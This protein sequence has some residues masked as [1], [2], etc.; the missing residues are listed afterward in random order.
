ML[1]LIAIQRQISPGT[2]QFFFMFSF[3]H[4]YL[5]IRKDL[6]LQEQKS[7][8]YVSNLKIFNLLSV[9]FYL[10]LSVCLSL[11]ISIC[12]P[13]FV[14]IL[15]P[16]CLSLSACRSVLWLLCLFTIMHLYLSVSLHVCPSSLPACV[17]LSIY[18]SVCLSVRLYLCLS[19]N[20]QKV[21]RPQG[22]NYG[23]EYQQENYTSSPLRRGK[24]NQRGRKTRCLARTKF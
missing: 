22:D 10:S 20:T 16:I 15:R 18:P 4:I 1:F 21:M 23:D 9:C 3:Q 11:Y 24:R 2:S 17:Y 12:I 6:L 8:H 7:C 13:V 14:F 19:V 5:R